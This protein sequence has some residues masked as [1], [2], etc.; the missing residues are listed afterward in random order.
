[1]PSRRRALLKIASRFCAPAG[2][3]A[4]LERARRLGRLADVGVG[5]R[6]VPDVDEAHGRVAGHPLAVAADGASSSPRGSG[7]ALKPLARPAMTT[8][9]A[10]RLTSHSQGPGSVSSKSLASKTRARSGEAKRPKLERWASPLA[11]TTMSVRGR[12]GE[13]EGHHG[14]RAPVV[15]EGRLGHALVA[16]RHEVLEPVLL[17]GRQ[18]GDRVATRRRLEG[19][20]AARAGRASGRPCR[21]ARARRRVDPGTR[22]PGGTRPGDSTCQ[23]ASYAA[24]VALSG[25]AFRG[26]ARRLR[27]LGHRRVFLPRRDGPAPPAGGQSRQTIGVVPAMAPGLAAGGRPR[28]PR[29][30]DLLA[31]GVVAPVKRQEPI[32]TAGTSTAPSSPRSR[33]RSAETAST[34]ASASR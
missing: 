28:A 30:P 15:G 32:R 29:R 34:A 3:G 22:R 10:S 1:M 20:V 26:C 5:D 16:Q 4:A 11:W 23:A 25:M 2:P 9:A 6:G 14:R 33:R 31:R 12:G 17:L 21:S 18:D 27:R 7:A 8:L 13:V 24:A 19:G